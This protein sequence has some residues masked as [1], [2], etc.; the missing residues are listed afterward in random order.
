MPNH[1]AVLAKMKIT[2]GWGYGRSNDNGRVSVVIVKR[3]E[4]SMKDG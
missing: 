1:I 2:D 4:M 3:L